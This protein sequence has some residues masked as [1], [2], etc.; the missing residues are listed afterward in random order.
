MSKDLQYY[1]DHP[2]EPLP[3]DPAVLAQ[4][5][6]G[7]NTPVVSDDPKTEEEDVKKEEPAPSGDEVKK[8]E[9][10]EDNEEKAITT[11]DGKGT[12][13]YEVLKTEREKRQAAESAVAELTSK[14]EEIQAQLAK[15]TTKGD[16]K[17][18]QLGEEALA[19]MSSEEL[20]AL[21]S[22]FPVFGKV[23]DS[24]MGTINS[25]SSEVTSLKQ[26]EQTREADTR[27]SVASTVQEL[28]DNEP[29]LAFLQTTDPALFD[30]AIAIDNTLKGDKRY[31]TMADRFSKVAELMETT[32]GPFEGVASKKAPT[33]SQEKPSVS[34][35]QVRDTVIKK[36]AE[37][38]AQPKSLSDIP[39]GEMPE[40][41]ELSNLENLSASEISDRMMKMSSDQ[42]T[43]F[44]K[45]F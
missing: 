22:D 28:I 15:G 39:A 43:A 7:M 2:D 44:L 31:P 8:E 27:R 12:I 26:S 9:P 41:D 34:K 35:E 33:T 20:D 11:R 3:D 18:E 4:L 21:R 38:K 5:A 6:E 25:L 29:V 24:L 13:P 45:R 1:L 32:F 42:R 30:K 19:T 23:I 17:A 37:T 36:V 14:V 40:S 16:A 10:K